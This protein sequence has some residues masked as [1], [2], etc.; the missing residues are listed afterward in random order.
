MRA[1]LN[2]TRKFIETGPNLGNP[3]YGKILYRRFCSDCHGENGEGI[4]APALNNQEFLNAASNGF[5][6]GTISIGRKDT[7]M[8]SWGRGTKQYPQL[9]TQD[10]WDIV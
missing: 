7:E 2:S 3:A 5:I 9:A 10:R 6:I 1:L 4:K 8:P